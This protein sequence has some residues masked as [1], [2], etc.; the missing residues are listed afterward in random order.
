MRLLLA[1]PVVLLVACADTAPPPASALVGAPPP[2]PSRFDGVWSG[3]MTRVYADQR[4]S[5]GP[6]SFPMTMT[7]AQGRARAGLPGQGPAGGT[8][9]PDNTMILRGNLDAAER[10]P[11][12]FNDNTFTARYQTRICAWE[13]RLTRSGAP[14]E[15]GS[16]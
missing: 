15:Q 11:G 8:V 1:L 4:A 16:R 9:L 14:A 5:C 10:A 13:M 7:I 2:P 3:T 6:E 12:R